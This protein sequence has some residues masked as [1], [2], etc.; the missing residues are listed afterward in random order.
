MNP[1]DAAPGLI[2]A[3]GEGVLLEGFR[4][5]GVDVMACDSEP[6]ILRAW[7]TLPPTTAV[8]LLTPRSARALGA[9]VTAVSAPLIVVLPA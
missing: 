3:I 8:V 9:A 1:A 7:T 5:A 4:L 6:D 2:A